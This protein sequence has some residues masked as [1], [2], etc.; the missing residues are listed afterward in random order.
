[1]KQKII[2]TALPNGID[3]RG[4]NWKISAAIG[5]QVEDVDATLQQVPDMLNWAQL[6]K[7]AKFI[8][9]V[10]GNSVEAKVTSKPVDT[11]LWQNLFTPAVKVKSF[12]QEDLSNIPIASYPV[13]HVLAFIKFVT[14]A[15]G[16]NFSTDLP[17]NNYFTENPI[18]QTLSDYQISE[19]KRKQRQSFK[20]GDFINKKRTGR[21]LKET[22][23]KTKVIPFD[24]KANP[25]MDFAQVKNF[26]GLYDKK[27][28]P[29]YAAIDPPNFEFHQ[30][31]AAL[32]TYPQLL[33][34]L[35]LIIDLEFPAQSSPLMRIGGSSS[36]RVIPHAINFQT[37]TQFVC[38]ATAYLKTTTGFYARGLDGSSIDKGYLKINTDGFT[39][40]QVDTD[41]AALKMCQQMDG[42]LL[43]KAKHIFYASEHMLPDASFIPAFNNE[44]PRKE[45][46]PSNRTAGIAV[47]KDGRAAAINASFKRMNDWK[48]KLMTGSAAPAGATGNNA[49]WILTTDL[50]YADDVNLGYRMDIQPEG[51]KWFSLHKRN[52]HYSYI[53]NGS[54]IDIP[55]IEMDEGFIQTAAS[56]EQTDTG[57]QLKVGEAL[58]RWEGWSLSVPRPG[59][60]LNDPLNDPSNDVYDKRVAGNTEKENAKWM[61]PGS[62]DFKLNVRPMIERGSLPMLRFG[63]KYSIKIRTVDMAGNSVDLEAKPEDAAASV[64]SGIRYMR[65]EPVEVPALVLGTAI[66]D[67]E[68]AEVVV[69]RSNE[70]STVAQYEAANIDSN[71]TSAF[72]ELAIRHVK[73]PR[74]SAEMAT[75]HS[76]L[77]KGMGSA[78]NVAAKSIY[79]DIVPKKDPLIT[80]ASAT[81][82]MSVTDGTQKQ[83]NI[84]YLIDPMAAGVTFYL[85]ANDLNP[86]PANPEVL[87]KRISFYTNPEITSDA[88]ADGLSINYDNWMNNVLTFRVIL[89]ETFGSEMPGVKWDG[90]E[91]KLVVTLPKGVIFKMNYAS[92]WRPS[93]VVKYSGT[94]DMMGMSN[95]TGAVGQRIA[96]G[97]HWMFSPFRE[98]TFVHA[99][100]QPLKSVGTQ[101]YPD[102]PDLYIDRDFATTFAEV[103][104]RQMVHGPSTDKVELEASWTEWVDDVTHTEAAPNELND[105]V[106]RIPTKQ[107]VFHFSALYQASEYVWGEVVKGNPFGPVQHKFNDTKHRRVIY[108]TIASTRYREYFF[109]LIKDKGTAFALTR[110]SPNS[111]VKYIPSS[112]RPVAPQVEYVIPT[113]EWERNTS[114]L[115]MLTARVSG[116]RVYLR[117][118]WYSSG[119]GEQLAVIL[120]LNITDN[121]N[122]G[123]VPVTTWGTDPTKMSAALPNNI[124]PDAAK[125]LKVDGDNLVLAVSPVENETKKVSAVAYD[126]KYDKERQL[127]YADIMMDIKSAYYPFV[128]LALARYQKYSVKKNN[129]DCCLSAI[130][131]TDY[132]QVPPPR[133]SSVKFAGPKNVV[134]VAISGTIPNLPTAGAYYRPKV[135]FL[136]EEIDHPATED[137]HITIGN[138]VIAE[139]T[140]F[141]QANQI[142]NNTFVFQRQFTLP[143]EYSTKAYRIKVLEFEMITYD[144]LK[145]NPNPTGVNFGGPPMKDRLVYADVYEVN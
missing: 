89:R 103:H 113:F 1:M 22:L 99:V 57:T 52:N 18:M 34:R 102:M 8:V 60:S 58:A 27:P 55:G 119:E 79:N 65:Y 64:V 32:S 127:Y 19:Y 68:S 104:L 107:S 16:K 29:H 105:D 106:K 93:D 75:L 46:T 62:A 30:V 56:E 78:N 11:T 122:S 3:A 54:T 69:I 37:T 123:N 63:K 40:F 72:N 136:I 85:S 110:Q 82:V 28:V 118:P 133:L 39:V 20:L 144:P 129:T 114:G 132:I 77:D 17:G 44:A 13:K 25:E 24:P 121:L 31:L 100:Q 71:H 5:L 116:L 33:R 83:I 84:E 96:R 101:N 87:T 59:S 86:K 4:G 131:Q 109:Q 135:Q 95:L 7:T 38:P 145:P 91:R 26:H 21:L 124:R 90:A 128:R 2:V 98:I 137:T 35:G 125:F 51:S 42:L 47:A 141:I 9:Q 49:S 50:L 6:I 10:N 12:K 112:A 73:P 139:H 74:S 61:A 94:L 36:V 92:F 97:Q 140:E 80:E 53:K 15:T 120:Y 88:E 14:E 43:K 45:G 134:T 76:M 117:R 138:K 48:T 81:H 111:I 67:G 41:G 66:K 142:S 108:K 143:M 130:V 126:V 115:T 70:G 23:N